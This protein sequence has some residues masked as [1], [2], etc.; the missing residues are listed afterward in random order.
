MLIPT[1]IIMLIISLPIDADLSATASML[2]GV[3]QCYVAL[4]GISQHRMTVQLLIA[5]NRVDTL[6]PAL[7][8]KQTFGF[9]MCLCPPPWK[10]K[11]H[12]AAL[13]LSF[14]KNPIQSLHCCAGSDGNKQNRHPRC[15]AVA[16]RQDRPKDRVPQPQ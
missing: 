3:Q 8:C 4:P 2:Q 16:A 5:T 12:V 1:L 9:G 13:G 7:F 11:S 10:K 15:C 14:N 6:G